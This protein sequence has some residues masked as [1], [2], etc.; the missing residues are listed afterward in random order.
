MK[1]II[2]IISA[3]LSVF[4]LVACKDKK[5]GANDKPVTLAM[6]ESN[7][8]DSISAWIDQAFVEKAAEL[9]KGT[10]KIEL[11]TGGILGDN[12]SV[13][14]VMTQ[15]NSKIHIARVSPAALVAYGCEKHELLDIPFTFVSREHFWNFALSDTAQTIL[16]EPYEK[17]IGIK[18]LFFAEEGFRHFFST[19]KLNGVSD[20]KGHTIRSAGN[21]IMKEIITSLQGDP[22]A[23]SFSELYS[24]LQ[25]G[26]V[27]IAEQPIANYL[28]NHF[29]KIAP[30]MIL[31]GHQLG[32]TEVVISSQVWDSLSASQQKALIEAGKYAGEYCSKV[33]Q[34][35]ENKSRLTLKE[36][37]VQFVEVSDKSE[38]QAAC[39]DVIKGASQ[40]NPKLYKEITDLAK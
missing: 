24:S 26:I 1:K 35:A 6:A 5:N 37:G 14:K 32:V 4:S 13:M 7:P 40:T 29:N 22:V 34:E 19:S 10:I 11:H 31:D 38:W 17:K 36:E 30:Y 21:S 8:S 9:S 39:A 25:T 2:F 23:V 16:N 33:S 27:E 15:P 20:F 12:T 3:V 28:S 18:G